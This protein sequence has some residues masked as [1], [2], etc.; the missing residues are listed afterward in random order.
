MQVV[1]ANDVDKCTAELVKKA[2]KQIAIIDFLKPILNNLEE[3]PISSD[4]EQVVT[5]DMVHDA[6]TL[7][8]ELVRMSPPAFKNKTLEATD[9]LLQVRSQQCTNSFI[10]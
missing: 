2:H 5:I 7:K 4:M 3:H 6:E 9:T 10:P 1:D 8:T